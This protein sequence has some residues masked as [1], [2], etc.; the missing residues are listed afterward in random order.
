MAFNRGR[1]HYS[2]GYRMTQDPSLRDSMAYSE[3]QVKLLKAASDVLGGD[4]VLAR[5][6]DI[7]KTLLASLMSG[8]HRMPPQLLVQVIDIILKERENTRPYPAQ[9]QAEI[10]QRN[11]SD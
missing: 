6:L 5:E 9:A 8:R 1:S 4:D 11:P 10:P 3:S 2:R 7:R